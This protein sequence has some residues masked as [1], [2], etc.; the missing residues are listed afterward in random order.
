MRFKALAMAC[1]L[2]VVAAIAVTALLRS[3][4]TPVASNTEAPTT[5]AP[6]A[7][8]DPAS[9][10]TQTTTTIEASTAEASVPVHTTIE[11]VLHPDIPNRE[12]IV[13]LTPE[14]FTSQTGI[15]I[16]FSGSNDPTASQVALFSTSWDIGANVGVSG[17]SNTTPM[18]AVSGQILSL[19]EFIVDDADFDV[20]DLLPSLRPKLSTDG[21][22]FVV[23]VSAESSFLMF[24]QDILD[25]GGLT[26]SNTPTWDEVANIARAINTEETAGICLRSRPG[27]GDLGTTFTTVLNTFG[28]TWWD[29]NDD[30]SIGAAQAD[31]PE[32]REALEFYV[33]LYHDAGQDNANAGFE[34]CREL[35]D[36]GEVAMW[37]DSTAAASLLEAGPQGGNIGYAAAPTKLTDASNWLLS[38]NLAAH[39]ISDKPEA[40]WEFLSWAGSE[41]F[42]NLA[43][44]TFGWDTVHPTRA[45]TFEN[46][47]FIAANQP[48]A[49]ATLDALTSAPIDNPGTTPRPGTPG[50]QFVGVFGFSEAA[51][52]CTT[53]FSAVMAGTQTIDEALSRCQATLT[54]IGELFAG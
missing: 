38:W 54:E 36:N 35:F 1:G 8:D 24:R 3:N 6:P 22:L 32:F 43:G 18:Y 10:T 21:E 13:A 44:A 7:A 40:L 51:L 52:D 37:Y 14:H 27:E 2:L 49:Q 31:A 5:T 19:N 26:L 42:I 4:D 33:N 9:T 16:L 50:I 15:E 30:G 46:P 48:Y 53:E 11:F 41:E 29:A 20:D 45:S 39:A 47:D 17:G 34:E 28:G 12:A 25:A 23:P